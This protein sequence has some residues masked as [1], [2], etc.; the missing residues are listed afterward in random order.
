[1]SHAHGILDGLAGER[2]RRSPR[3]RGRGHSFLDDL[4][5]PVTEP[6]T[7]PV[8]FGDRPAPGSPCKCTPISPAAFATTR[9]PRLRRDFGWSQSPSGWLSISRGIPGPAA[10]VSLTTRDE[11][12]RDSNTSQD[13]ARDR[14]LRLGECAR[15]TQGDRIRDLG[16]FHARTPGQ[17]SRDTLEAVAMAIDQRGVVVAP[18][19]PPSTACEASTGDKVTCACGR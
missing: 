9:P 18:L 5:G 11:W 14:G 2:L 15:R 16:A 3:T 10:A 8:T 19:K 4:S 6:V 13:E 17:R 7:E 1:M 12:C